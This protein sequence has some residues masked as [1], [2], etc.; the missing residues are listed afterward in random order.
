METQ[1]ICLFAERFQQ[2]ES[3]ETELKY[4]IEGYKMCFF[5]SVMS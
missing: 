1:C 2:D 3:H 4:E 5:P